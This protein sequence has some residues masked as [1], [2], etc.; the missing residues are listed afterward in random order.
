[1]NM[2]NRKYIYKQVICFIV[3]LNCVGGFSLNAQERKK[4]GLVLGGGGAKG[5]AEVGVL[6]VLEEAGIPVDYIAGTSIGAI[7]GGLYAIG[8]DAATLDS[9]Y[10]NQDWM[11]LIKDQVKRESKAFL[12][13][14][15]KDKYLLH[16]PLSKEKKV[17][18]T[19]G[20]YVAGQNILNLFSKL[21]VGYHNVENFSDL[22]IP[23][24]CVTVDV[25]DGKEVVL[26]SGSL[27]LA[28]RASMSIPGAFAPVEW[29]DMLLV[30]GGALNNLPVDVVKEMGAEIIIC[31]DLST[32]WKEKE[33]LKSATIVLDQLFGIMAQPK[34]RVNREGADL[35]I[36]PMLKGYNAASFQPEAIDTMLLRGELAA[37]KK[38]D[39]LI[40]LRQ[41]I[42]NGTSPDTLSRMPAKRESNG[43][44]RIGQI[45]IEGIDDREKEWIRK[46]IA[47]QEY[48]D[49]E[50]EKIDRVL[51]KL[52]G[53]D[54][55]SRVEYRLSNTAPHNLIFLLEMKDSRRINIGGRFD[56]EE[57]AGIIVNTSNN[58]Q[59]GTN[60]H[61][62]VTGR[63]S[64]NPYLE[65]EYAFGHLFGAKLGIS[66]R[67]GYHDFNLYTG[68]HDVGD[69]EFMSHT[70]RGYYTRDI[71]NFR[72]K[73]GMQFEYFDYRSDL[74]DR[75]G[76]RQSEHSDFFLNYFTDFTMDTYDRV[77]FPT[78]GSQ[79]QLQGVMYTDNGFSYDD[80][81][82]FGAFA[83]RAATAIRLSSRFYMLPA[84][85]GRFVFGNDI[86]PIYQNY[87]GG[88]FE[89]NYLP[90]QKAWESVQGVHIVEKNFA[91][92]KL[93]LRYQIDKK[94]YVT[95]LGEYG[96]ET[97]EIEDM[98]SG[99]D[100]WGCALRFSYDFFLGPIA[101]QTNY[102]NLHKNVG[103]Y[104]N[105]G[106]KF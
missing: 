4:V 38:W 27:P 82:P 57:V 56:T 18:F 93:A 44:Y 61:Y 69:M 95:A 31:V 10:R 71:A 97:H 83:F 15:E 13:K 40:A 51:A 49:I 63:I 29:D 37:R 14:E 32:G 98:F 67:M 106:F 3:M 11:F 102:S 87:V 65:A 17:A 68:K 2:K 90:W 52:Q 8:Y 84:L 77:Y 36:N 6:K 48:S 104:I 91:A 105:A 72:M 19:S 80:D 73:A 1:M 9:L 50:Q 85:K 43:T 54:I 66:Y 60:H 62:S 42:Y 47:L 96:K 22:P 75:H 58:Q 94:I 16:V 55:F 100:L 41:I 33:A 74:F 88:I 103:F 30:D 26:D 81:S 92:A 7:V 53:F 59:L 78:R 76:L 23:F 21:T 86:S 70:I 28:M 79:I 64:K 89:A 5:A 39:E 35:Y 20:G 24:R 99:D 45:E 12:S 101:I 46:Q 25:V 34:Y